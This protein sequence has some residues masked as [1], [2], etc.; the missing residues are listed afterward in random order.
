VSNR[1]FFYDTDKFPIQKCAIFFKFKEIGG[2]ARR[3]TNVCLTSDS[4]E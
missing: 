2:I 3:H 4:A 1:I